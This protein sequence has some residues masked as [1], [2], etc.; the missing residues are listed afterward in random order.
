M[1]PTRGT[2][3]VT[4]SASSAAR[5]SGSPRSRGSRAAA[6]AISS[7]CARAAASSAASTSS[8]MC[9]PTRTADD[10]RPAQRGQRRP[11][12]PCPAGPSSPGFSETRT[13]NVNF[14]RAPSA[15]DPGRPR[16]SP[17]PSHHAHALRYQS[18]GSPVMRSYASR[19]FSAVRSIDLGGQL[20]RRRLVV[21]AARVEPVAHELLV[22]ARLRPARARSASAGQN[23]E[24]S[25]VPTSSIRISSPSPNP[26]SNFVSATMMPRSSGD[27]GDP[28]VERERELLQPLGEARADQVGGLLERERQVVALGGLRGGREDR[29]GQ[30]V[31][32]D[33]AGRAA[34]T[35]QTVPR[36]RYSLQPEPLR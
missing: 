25:G 14:M 2:P 18:N 10:V 22:E 31:G 7:T 5:G 4:L 27:R 36:S 28:L 33:E 15:G 6:R 19:Y 23:R 13:S 11:R 34:R 35:P 29:L 9:L 1:T 12:P 24:E 8:S 3:S 26:N 20:G 32:L 17:S 30:A 21:P 16:T